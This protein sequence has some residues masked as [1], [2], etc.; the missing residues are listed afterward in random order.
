MSTSDLLESFESQLK[1]AWMNHHYLRKHAAPL[2]MTIEES[3]DADYG[4]HATKQGQSMLVVSNDKGGR[5][6]CKVY[7]RSESR[8][9]AFADGRYLEELVGGVAAGMSQQGLLSRW[10]TGNYK[11]PV[12]GGRLVS[13]VA[14]E[15]QGVEAKEEAVVVVEEVVANV[16]EEVTTAEVASDAGQVSPIIDTGSGVEFVLDGEEG[17]HVAVVTGDA[18]LVTTEPLPSEDVSEPVAV[19]VVPN[20]EV[21]EF[22]DAMEDEAELEEE[23]EV[24][25]EKAVEEEVAE[26]KAVEDVAAE[27]DEPEP[28]PEP[29]PE[30]T[31]AALPTTPSPTL[32]DLGITGHLAK[33]LTAAGVNTLADIQAYRKANG[34]LE[35]IKG[36]GDDR[37]ADVMEKIAAWADLDE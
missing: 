18:Q 25:E 21:D 34:S 36:I 27:A 32:S 9:R 16:A 15:L 4:L 6:S 20:D 12:W 1:L 10:S 2:A 17:G 26:E 8:E 22:L 33:L 35:P 5:L 28:E 29:E 7:L 24:T 30:A 13:Q 3:A 14:V 19:A 31:T 37:D 23:R 11:I